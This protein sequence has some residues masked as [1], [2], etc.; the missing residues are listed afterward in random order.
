S[1]R[2]YRA[3]C[4]APISSRRRPAMPP[5][6]LTL[7]TLLFA[8][9]LAL[10][11]AGWEKQSRD[12]TGFHAELSVTHKDAV[13]GKE[14]RYTGAVVGLTSGRARMRLNNL[15]D[16]NDYE[17][18][19]CDGRSVYLYSGLE[20]SVTEFRL[21]PPSQ[22]DGLFARLARGMCPTEHFAVR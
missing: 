2:L 19:I 5:L 1:P 12:L 20:K 16:K 21:S 14:R 8:P 4:R 13:F 6:G 22:P 9:Q 15:H 17:A 3:G 10:H 11:L 18:V 7:A